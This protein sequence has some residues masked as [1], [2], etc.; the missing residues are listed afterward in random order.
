MLPPF[1]SC[2]LPFAY[3]EES[4]RAIF[5]L[6]SVAS[7]KLH[8]IVPVFLQLLPTA[9]PTN[10]PQYEVLL[11][12]YLTQVQVLSVTA[13]VVQFV[14]PGVELLAEQPNLLILEASV[15]GPIT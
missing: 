14:A 10:P 4:A 9:V 6:S 3:A 12:V 11:G 2:I 7:L 8:S 15:N 13:S 5:P 1:S